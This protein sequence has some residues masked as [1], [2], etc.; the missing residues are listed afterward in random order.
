[1]DP[2]IAPGTGTAVNGGITYREAHLAMEMLADS[3]LVTSL[4]VVE[5]NPFLDERGKTAI[6][7]AEL[8]A[9]LFGQRI[10]E[11]VDAKR[12]TASVAGQAAGRMLQSD[13]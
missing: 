1:M 8:I 7:L 12:F 10:F 11:T 13:R 5:L 4:D 9:S 2:A 3:A 6:L